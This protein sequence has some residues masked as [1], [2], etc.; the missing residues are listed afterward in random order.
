MT[1]QSIC[2]TKLYISVA[3]AH[4]MCRVGWGNASVLLPPGLRSNKRGARFHALFRLTY[5]ERKFK[6][7]INAHR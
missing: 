1:H 2:A 3:Y 5:F 7:K 6:A 4:S